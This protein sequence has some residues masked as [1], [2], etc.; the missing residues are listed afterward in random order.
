MNKEQKPILLIGDTVSPQTA[1]AFRQDGRFDVITASIGQFPS[2]GLFVELFRGEEKLSE[3]NAAKIKGAKAYILQS[4]PESDPAAFQHMLTMAHTLKWYGASSVTAVNPF[5][6]NM[7]QDRSLKDRFTSVA[8]DLTAK[9]MAAAGIDSVYTVTPHSKDAIKHY[10]KIFGDD[11]HVV[12]TTEMF[13]EDIK[14]RFDTSPDELSIGAPDG[15]DKMGDEGQQRARDLTKAVFGKNDDDAMFR[16]SKVH[17]GVSDTKITSF[18]GDVA[19]KDAVLIDDMID[20]GSTTINAANILKA[21][22][23]KSVTAYVTHPLL[24]GNAL[25]NLLS[26]K[27]DG[28][29]HAIDK[30]VVT[31][32]IPDVR[33]KLRELARIRPS[34]AN[35]VEILSTAP[36]LLKQIDADQKQAAVPFMQRRRAPGASG[37]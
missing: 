3:E 30:I 27:P 28:M 18:N 34:L 29:N 22:G 10:E 4:A 35:R 20:G 5:L 8:A 26:A 23:A 1:D 37:P 13:A 32:S 21:H 24:T 14:Q 2:G 36:A 6:P 12:T 25:E 15:A 17:T 31:D 16:I 11:F 33:R 7:R 19:A 9:Q